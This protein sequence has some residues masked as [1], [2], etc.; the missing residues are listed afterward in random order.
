M[1]SSPAMKD[2]IKEIKIDSLAHGGRGVGRLE[3]KA[4]FVPL[5]APGDKVLFHPVKEKKGY[6]EGELVEVVKPSSLRR[7]P[8]CAVYGDC[9]GC[10]WQ[11]LPYDDQAAAKESIFRETLWRLGTVA[12]EAFLP[13]IPAPSEWRYRNRAQFK[14]HFAEGKL[15]VGFYRRKSHV[16]ID[17]ESC[18]LM[19]PLI[20]DVMKAMKGGLAN[21]PFRESMT[22]IEI[23]VNDH[24]NRAVAVVH[25]TVHPSKEELR[26]AE[27]Q[28]STIEALAGL[29]FQSDRKHKMI[30]AF[31]REDG[32]L[33]YQLDSGE[34]N[35][36]LSFSPGGFTQVNYVQ[37]R[38]LVEEVLALARRRKPGRLLDLYAGIGN[39]S[40]PLA[41]CTEEVIAIEGYAGAIADGERNAFAGGIKNCR[42]ITGD[43]LKELNKLDL[44]TFD[45]VL[46]DPPR[47]GAA[48]VMKRLATSGIPTIIYVSCNPATLARDLRY[49]TREGY[50]I[51]S[52]QPIDLFPQ[53]YHIESITVAEKESSPSTRRGILFFIL[54]P[55]L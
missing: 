27:K 37:N 23:A 54:S 11:H 5:T 46:I 31:A 40:L 28:L 7:E 24:D 2:D 26:F 43:A 50:K 47:V 22:Q 17:I 3:G 32:L 12:E 1:L 30:K 8:P 15:H 52:S 20:N 49:L 35:M 19:S 42:F 13:I 41:A 29:F 51:K 18:P 21:A 4:V 16:V 33:S 38:R 14:T 55:N 36:E 6:I 25:L 44:Q 53:T 48:P 45:T 10:N 34:K 39:F 9:G